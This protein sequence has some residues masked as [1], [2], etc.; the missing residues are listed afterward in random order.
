MYFLIKTVNQRMKN[1]KYSNQ[2]KIMQKTKTAL[3]VLVII[4]TVMFAF[5]MC[6]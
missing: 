4:Y 5:Q 6:G 2:K 3:I 1:P